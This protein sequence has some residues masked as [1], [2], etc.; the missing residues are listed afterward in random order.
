MDGHWQHEIC[1]CCQ[2]QDLQGWFIEGGVLPFNSIFYVTSQDC[3]QD[4]K[5][6]W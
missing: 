4:F 2:P 1:A 5:D 6:G 3:L